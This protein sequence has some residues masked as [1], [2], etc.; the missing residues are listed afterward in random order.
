MHR[1]YFISLT[2]FYKLEENGKPKNIP[3]KFYIMELKAYQ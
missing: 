2:S 1:Y 3:L